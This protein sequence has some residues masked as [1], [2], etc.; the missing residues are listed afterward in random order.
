[1]SLPGREEGKE[2]EL[3]IRM[4]FRGIKNENNTENLEKTWNRA[5]KIVFLAS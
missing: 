4:I 2:L 3:R 1:M 5:S